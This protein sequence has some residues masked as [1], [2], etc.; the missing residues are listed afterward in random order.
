MTKGLAVEL[1]DVRTLKPY[2]RNAKKHPPEQVQKLKNSI[3]IY[4]WKAPLVV[5]KDLEIIIGHGRTLAAIELGKETGNYLAPVV[6]EKDLDKHQANALRLADNRSTS[7][8][9]DMSL[10]QENLRELAEHFA[11][12]EFDLGELTAFDEHELN[13]ST[14]DL[15]DLDEGMFVDDIGGAVEQQKTENK[16]AAEKL[17]G[18]VAAPIGDALGFKRVTVE[19]SRQVRS[20]MGKIEA[21]TGKTGVEALIAH[22][23]ATVNA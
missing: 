23:S 6:V 14:E 7:N 4:G 11:G 16:A 3:R 9:Y 12:T 21:S 22:F 2:A 10:V 17:D 8:E 13:F 18:D 19:Q 15:G 5:D 20:F 1:L